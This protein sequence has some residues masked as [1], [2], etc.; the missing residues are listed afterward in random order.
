MTDQ[1][2][3]DVVSWLASQRAQNPGRPYSASNYTQHPEK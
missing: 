1:E 3:T 2:I